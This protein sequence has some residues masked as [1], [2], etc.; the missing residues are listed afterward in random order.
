MS[1]LLTRGF[2]VDR[3]DDYNRDRGCFFIDQMF[4]KRTGLLRQ[5]PKTMGIWSSLA[6]LQ[7]SNKGD[8]RLTDKGLLVA[9]Y[10]RR[11]VEDLMVK[12]GMTSRMD[13]AALVSKFEYENATGI[14]TEERAARFAQIKALAPWYFE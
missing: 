4:F 9:A 11:D 14:M 8:A 7:I 1:H 6:G 10:D 3:V 12:V 5:D 13:L 2:A